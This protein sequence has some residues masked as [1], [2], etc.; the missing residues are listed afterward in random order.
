V[1]AWALAQNPET[2]RIAQHFDVAH[3]RAGAGDQS[4]P[5]GHTRATSISAMPDAATFQTSE[6]TRNTPRA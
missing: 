4:S 3:G 2:L 6:R 1:L 5:Y